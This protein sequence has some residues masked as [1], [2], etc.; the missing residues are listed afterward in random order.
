MAWRRSPV[1]LNVATD[2]Q[3]PEEGTVSVGDDR[4]VLQADHQS[5]TIP[6]SDIANVVV[7]DLP[8]TLRP[9]PPGRVPVTLIYRHG[10]TTTNALVAGEEPLMNEFTERLSRL[11]DETFRGERGG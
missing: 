10:D 5:V 3:H 6:A 2:E 1:W 9:V 11:S 4:V 8:R 7:G